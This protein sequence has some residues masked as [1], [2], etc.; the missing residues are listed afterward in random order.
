[1]FWTYVRNVRA[2]SLR[3]HGWPSRPDVVEGLE[4]GRKL[5]LKAFLLLA[6]FGMLLTGCWIGV[7]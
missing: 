1:M 6:F 7:A 5:V 2:Q 4:V 3:N